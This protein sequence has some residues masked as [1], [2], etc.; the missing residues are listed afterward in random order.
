[1]RA[2]QRLRRG[3]DF[4]AVFRDG[5]RLAD[6]ALGLRARDRRD[7]APARFGFAVSSRL[8]NAV[9]RNRIRRRLRESARRQDA[10]GMDIVVSAR[11]A[12][13]DA[14]YHQLHNTLTAL[15]QRA[16]ERLR[17]PARQRR[18]RSDHA[19]IEATPTTPF[20]TNGQRLQ[21]RS[22]AAS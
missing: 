21:L 13:A 19:A 18:P 16:K 6:G 20:H 3:R 1:M 2:D 14:D 15:I 9:V 7:H 5:I 11:N 10:D 4:D 12:A 17:Q 22:R 8:G